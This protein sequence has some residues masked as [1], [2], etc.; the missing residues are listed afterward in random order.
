MTLKSPHTAENILMFSAV[1]I[2]NRLFYLQTFVILY[3][4]DIIPVSETATKTSAA[5]PGIPSKKAQSWGAILSI[6][7]IVLMIVVGAFYAW[8]KRVAQDEYNTLTAPSA[9]E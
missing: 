5:I 1:S 3:S 4:M 6:I 8:G 9:E 2:L 7:V